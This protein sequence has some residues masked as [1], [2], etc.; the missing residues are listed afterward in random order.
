MRICNLQSKTLISKRG[1][2]DPAVFLG[3]KGTEGL[4]I[5]QLYKVAKL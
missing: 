1:L 2:D 3:G 5:D 4:N